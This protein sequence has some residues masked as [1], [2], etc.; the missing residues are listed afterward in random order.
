MFDYKYNH[1][2]HHNKNQRLLLDI[3][4]KLFLNKNNLYPLNFQKQFSLDSLKQHEPNIEFDQ[5]ILVLKVNWDDLLL[6]GKQQQ[7]CRIEQHHGCI[8]YKFEGQLLL[9]VH[10]LKT[11]HLHDYRVHE[12]FQLLIEIVFLPSVQHHIY[13]Q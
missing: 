5:D 11:N 2:R 10:H 13:F 9:Y 1:V 4:L 8:E 6:N 12:Y 3:F 7:E